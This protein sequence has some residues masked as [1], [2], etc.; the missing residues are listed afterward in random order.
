[1]SWDTT[2]YIQIGGS[3]IGGIAILAFFAYWAKYEKSKKKD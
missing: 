2:Q 1:M 3:I